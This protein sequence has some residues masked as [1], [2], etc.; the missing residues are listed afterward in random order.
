MQRTDLLRM[1]LDAGAELGNHTYSH[2]SLQ[3]TELAAY[4]EDVIRGEKTISLLMKERGLRLRYFRYPFLQTG[5]DLAT[6]NAFESFLRSR[7]YTNAPVTIDNSDWEFN[8]VYVD[9]LNH[10][11]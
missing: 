11:D 3:R 9:A 2:P 7:G 10:R 6:R 8:T 1:W 4:E 5:P